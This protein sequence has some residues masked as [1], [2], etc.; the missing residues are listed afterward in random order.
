MSNV[1]RTTINLLEHRCH[2]D[3]RD[4]LNTSGVKTGSKV[5]TRVFVHIILIE[6]SGNG[7]VLLVL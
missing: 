7:P 5:R 1:L 4:D 2:E 3:G 6:I